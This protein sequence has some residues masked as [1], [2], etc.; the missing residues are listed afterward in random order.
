MGRVA[1]LRGRDVA[2]NRLSA[3]GNAAGQDLASFLPVEVPM[4]RQPRPTLS[5]ASMG[6]FRGPMKAVFTVSMRLPSA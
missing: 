3:A 4:A 1:L 5:A 6:Y 2:D